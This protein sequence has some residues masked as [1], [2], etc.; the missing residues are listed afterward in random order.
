M[1]LIRN[2]YLG[3]KEDT[4]KYKNQQQFHFSKLGIKRFDSLEKL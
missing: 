2:N 3:H 4:Q 1:I